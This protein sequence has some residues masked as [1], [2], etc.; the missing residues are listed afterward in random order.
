MTRDKEKVVQWFLVGFLLVSF[1]FIFLAIPAQ[2]SNF[3]IDARSEHFEITTNGT[4]QLLS[5]STRTILNVSWLGGGTAKSWLYCGNVS[6][7]NEILD[8]HGIDDF[9]VDMSFLC[10]STIIQAF[11]TGD[12]ADDQH[13][14][15]TWVD[16]N[17]ASSTI[18]SMPLTDNFI[19]PIVLFGIIVVFW[20]WL[21]RKFN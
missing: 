2:A 20:V 5:T 7:E 6:E 3:P 17:L 10:E 8:T 19:F 15:L 14:I 18:T 9:S 21:I 16:Y 12:T 13:Y 11:T 4:S 1:L